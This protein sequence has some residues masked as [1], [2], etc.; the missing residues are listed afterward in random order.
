MKPSFTKLWDYLSCQLTTA[1][2]DDKSPPTFVF[3]IEVQEIYCF[4]DI[5]GKIVD[6]DKE[7]LMRS[8]FEYGIKSAEDKME[9]HGHNW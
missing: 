7:R 9:I 5:T 8:T 2:F 3:R 1:K 4:E 6:G